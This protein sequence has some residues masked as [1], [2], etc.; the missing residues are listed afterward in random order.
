MDGVKKDAMDETAAVMNDD[1]TSTIVQH[2][3]LSPPPPPLSCNLD[4]PKTVT[5]SA[6][7]ATSAVSA[8]SEDDNGTSGQLF[9]FGS[10]SYGMMAGIPSSAA[11]TASSSSDS[12]ASSPLAS[13]SD[14]GNVYTPTAVPSLSTTRI[15]SIALG[16]THALLTTDS[17]VTLAFGDNYEGQLGTGN[18]TSHTTPIPIPALDGR[19]ITRLSA[20][21]AHS[22]AIS[23]RGELF[24]WGNGELGQLGV[25]QKDTGIHRW[26]NTTHTA[27][28]VIKQLAGQRVVKV[29]TGD[30]FTIALTETGQ[31]F[32]CGDAHRGTVG[33]EQGRGWNAWNDERHSVAVFAPISSLLPLPIIDI[34]AGSHHTLALTAAG[35]VYSF[36]VGRRG[37]LGH[38]NN[39]NQLLP[40][41]IEALEKVHVVRVYAGG[42]SSA[43]LSVEG[44]VWMFGNNN[45]GQLGVGDADSRYVPSLVKEG[46]GEGKRVV[47]VAMGQGHTLLLADDHFVYGMGDNS[48]GALGL[49]VKRDEDMQVDAGSDSPNAEGEEGGAKRQKVMDV[50]GSGWSDVLIPTVV[51]IPRGRRVISIAAGSTSSAVILSFATSC[52][53]LPLIAFPPTLSSYG[54]LHFDMQTFQH[55]I[56]SAR[57]SSSYA[58]VLAYINRIFSSPTV[59]NMSFFPTSSNRSLLSS[60]PSLSRQVSLTNPD[61]VLLATTLPNSLL[62][63]SHR[64]VLPALPTS[65]DV[66]TVEDVYK[67][68]LKESVIEPKLV[69]Q[70]NH[71]IHN[72][73]N[74]LLERMKQAH[75]PADALAYR[76]VAIAMQA[77][78]LSAVSDTNVML[79]S[80]MAKIVERLSPPVR[81]VIRRWFSS[82]PAEI[83]GSRLVAMII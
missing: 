44:E 39:T 12:S 37:Q 30:D 22:A 20:A 71:A 69:S 57:Q 38:A 79:L 21:F 58:P 64:T 23:G 24:T 18:R 27:P 43:V 32:A 53:P 68:I 35:E 81:K 55:T 16:S 4:A 34:A 36:G 76:A 60:N 14:E 50:D 70:C 61:P 51:P 41:R 9:M 28:T 72:A 40:K 54:M 8:L 29:V 46:L 26:D 7:S 49:G 83:F 73:I 65:I 82:Y 2:S 62:S 13:S 33:L 10:G 56:D 80:D 52:T 6:S 47:D 11:S 66:E 74:S 59:L 1:N 15:S 17:G 3:P 25:N 63:P 19:Y 75:P 31:L 5:E 77:P 48:L 78:F 42:D 45:R 67:A